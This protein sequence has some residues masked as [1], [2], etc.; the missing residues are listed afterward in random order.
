MLVRGVLGIGCAL[1]VTVAGCGSGNFEKAKQ[2][3]EK[4]ANSLE[5]I[6]VALES[7]QSPDDAG[8]AAERINQ[9]TANMRETLAE[10]HDVKVTQSEMKELQ[11]MHHDRILD[12]HTR[13]I[14]AEMKARTISDNNPAL[15]QAMLRFRTLGQ[16]SDN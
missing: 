8:A 15:D 9:V 6:A 14:T 10:G 2:I 5:E 13:L 7:V 3:N 1:V 11:E 4:L 16:S 12:L